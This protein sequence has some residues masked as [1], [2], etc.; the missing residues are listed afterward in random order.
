MGVYGL[1]Q[2]TRGSQSLDVT[3]L[4]NNSTLSL[5]CYSCLSNQP[6]IIKRV[7]SMNG[8]MTEEDMPCWS[9]GVNYSDV[10]EG[11]VRC[12]DVSNPGP[13]SLSCVAWTWKRSNR[14][15]ETHHC[16]PRNG[17]AQTTWWLSTSAHLKWIYRAGKW[18]K[19]DMTQAD[20]TWFDRIWATS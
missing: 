18:N 20:Q 14:R 6:S 12:H 7:N 13:Q 11:Q 17:T 1:I 16:W 9:C 8:V 2:N 15:S 19:R 5:G 4:N 3:T 10:A